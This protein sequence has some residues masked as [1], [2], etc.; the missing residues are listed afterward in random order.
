MLTPVKIFARRALGAGY[1]DVFQM[2]LEINYST[3]RPVPGAL[4]RDYIS[5]TLFE[6]QLR[7]TSTIA[8]RQSS[9]HHAKSKNSMNR[10]LDSGFLQLA[11]YIS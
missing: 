7:F 4:V 2:A 9:A 6:A 3:L 10:F 11:T 5:S 8:A 1:D